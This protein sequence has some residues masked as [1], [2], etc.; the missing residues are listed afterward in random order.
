MD[1]GFTQRF[2]NWVTSARSRSVFDHQIFNYLYKAFTSLLS[3]SIESRKEN[4][5][6]SRSQ[7]VCVGRGPC[8]CRYALFIPSSMRCT[9]GVLV[10][11]FASIYLHSCAILWLRLVGLWF[12]THAYTLPRG[13]LIVRPEMPRCVILLPHCHGC[14]APRLHLL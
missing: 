8:A 14:H 9:A 13:Q 12:S 7:A 4:K 1:I 10:P 11:L 6:L 5:P 2:S 3:T